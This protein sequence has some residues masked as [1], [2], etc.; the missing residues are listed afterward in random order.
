MWVLV[1]LHTEC[2]QRLVHL[3]SGSRITISANPRPNSNHA[4][5]IL[6]NHT[7]PPNTILHSGTVAECVEYIMH[8]WTGLV[9]AGEALLYYGKEPEKVND[10][11]CES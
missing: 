9:R 1:A 4:S 3:E 8:T 10:V 7:D 2:A 5:V 11:N 6:H